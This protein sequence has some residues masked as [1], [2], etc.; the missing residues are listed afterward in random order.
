MK[1]KILKI[2]SQSRNVSSADLVRKLKVSRQYLNRFIKEMLAD[3]SIIKF[4]K[5]RNAKYSLAN[6][7]N[8]KILASNQFKFQKTLVNQNLHESDIFNS[9]RQEINHLFKFPK[10]I[11]TVIRYAFTEMFNNAIDHSRSKFI[12]VNAGK[13]EN[14]FFFEIIDRGIGIFNNIK[15]KK[16]LVSELEA[17]RDLLKG[18]QTTLPKKHSG[19]GIFF[20]SK[21]ADKLII[22]SS[23]I[24]LIFDNRIDDVFINKCRKCRGTKIYFE[25]DSNSRTKLNSIF[26]KYTGTDYSFNKSEI[27]IRLF[28]LDSEFLSRSEA[29]RVMLGLE[30]FE[31]IVLDFDRVETVGQGFADEIF[32]VWQSQNPGITITYHNAHPNVEFM[33]KRALA[34]K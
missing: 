18:K 9:L 22:E 26:K 11:E 20:T 32:R 19:E 25:I 5:T 16:K 17:V 7:K 31:I 28:N 23:K 33:L 1:D 3:G 8:R 13:K 24:K 6:A 34:T 10:N 2:I 12:F 15:T 14:I 4:G 30:K 27:K 21:V 29:K